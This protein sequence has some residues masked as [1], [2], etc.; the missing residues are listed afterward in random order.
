MTYVLVNLECGHT[1]D[2]SLAEVA[3]LQ[4]FCHDKECHSSQNILSVVLWEW[5]AFC[6]D[7]NYKRYYG[8]NAREA[9]AAAARHY[10][11]N[12][13]HRPGA[14]RGQRPDAL[15]A[16]EMVTKRTGVAR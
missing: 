3:A 15:K 2:A 12:N 16:Q 6:Y 7:C 14:K 11:R 9:E 8:N 1:A 13:D 10:R 4:T 5:F